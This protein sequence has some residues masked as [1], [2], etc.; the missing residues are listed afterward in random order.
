[1]AS[2]QKF[3]EQHSSK[4][5]LA[6]FWVP[7]LYF[8]EGIPYF[9]V[10]NIS[11]MMFAKMGV[12]NGQLAFFTTLLYFPWFLKGLWS[13]IVDVIKTKRWWII[14]MQALMVAAM[15]LLT[16]TLPKPANVCPP[17]ESVSPIP[18]EK[19]EE[20]NSLPFNSTN[21]AIIEQENFYDAIANNDVEEYLR[22][23]KVYGEKIINLGVK[24]W[25]DYLTKKVMSLFS[26]KELVEDNLPDVSAGDIIHLAEYNRSVLQWKED[27]LSR[28]AVIRVFRSNQIDKSV[29][30]NIKDV[31]NPPTDV[32]IFWLTLVLFII[33]AFAS[34][35]HDISADGYYLLAHD[36]SSQA[37][38]IGIRSTFYRISSVFGQGVLVLIAGVI[39]KNSGNIPFSWQVTLGVSAI[40]FAV[41]TLYHIFFLPKSTNDRPRD[42]SDGGKVNNWKEIGSSFA[43]F[44]QK[45]GVWLAIAF[46]LLYRLPEGFL[47]KMCQP[48]LVA[49][50]GLNL[51]TEMVG[52]VYGTFGVIALLAGGIVGGIVASRMG[53]KKSLWW[54]ALGMTLPC[55]TFVYLAMAVPTNP[56]I[57]TIALAIEQ[58]GY[59][60]GFTAYMLYMMYFSEGEFK[61]SHYAICTAFMALSMMLPGFVAGFIQEAIGYVWFF[62]M[63]MMCCVA[64][65]AVTY[66]AER[67]VDPNYGKK[68]K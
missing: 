45:K 16:L 4:Q 19:L 30:L 42:A 58:F 33:T 18:Q 39:E 47:I 14:A 41:I 32:S 59:G 20:I 29:V 49:K 15:V 53:L 21:F 51:P 44:F 60:F 26:S 52:I 56:V 57:I 64:T 54:M 35:T 10:N 36:Q 31:S 43:T 27:N 46:M 5:W 55:L 68:V 6:W 62:W 37:A 17:P 34:A 23:D 63:V 50:D 2:I 48:F 11:V 28:W 7:T 12:P 61:T 22:L 67:K 65:V 1:M 38:F 24:P 13:P 40:V 25:V 9:L 3:Y 8:A 66:L